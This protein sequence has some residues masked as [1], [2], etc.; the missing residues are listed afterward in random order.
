MSDKFY[1]TK[2]FKKLQREWY[3]KLADE[4]FVDI[5]DGLEDAEFLAGAGNVKSEPLWSA[6]QAMGVG[7]A[8]EVH[9]ALDA[10]HEAVDYQRGYV[11]SYY[12]AATEVVAE[13]MRNGEDPK[14]VFVW[15]H[16]A[17]GIGDRTIIKAALEVE[18]YH[19]TRYEV[20]KL[21]N[22]FKT[23]VISRLDERW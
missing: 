23:I 16:L 6:K 15:T 11:A 22:E 3:G 20:R 9:D 14:R 1:K 2:D 12:R 21:A 17:E 18:G 13:A 19:L 10:S 4:G 5:E 8:V 7:P